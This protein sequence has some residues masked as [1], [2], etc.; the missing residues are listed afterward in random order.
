MIFRLYGY[1]QFY[2]WFEPYTEHG[3]FVTTCQYVYGA[4]AISAAVCT[5]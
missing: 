3:S 5:E 2:K 1:T 4:I